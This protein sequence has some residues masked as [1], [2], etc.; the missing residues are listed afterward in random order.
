MSLDHLYALLM[1]TPLPHRLLPASPFSTPTQAELA[2][3]QAEWSRADNPFL[4]NYVAYH[5]FRSLGWVVKSGIKFCAD[6]LLY[7]R[8]P[9]FSHA[10]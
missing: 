3:V 10:E 7:K 4:L 8:G 5:H 2:Q 1:A 6:F 9:A